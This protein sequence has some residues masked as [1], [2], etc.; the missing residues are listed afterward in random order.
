MKRKASR[1]SIVL[2]VMVAIILSVCA[3]GSFARAAKKASIKQK[4]LTVVVGKTKKI[5]VVHKNKKR[6]YVFSTNRNKIATVSKSG[7]VRGKKA[8]KAVITVKET[9][10]QKKKNKTRVVGKVTVNVKKNTN[11][12]PVQKGTQPPAPSTVP[13]AS[14]EPGGSPASSVPEP[15]TEPSGNKPS[16]YVSETGSDSADG[17]QS[18]PFKTLS[19]AKEAVRNLDK[20][21]GDIVVEIADGFYPVEEPVVFTREDSGTDGCTIT[22]RAAEGAKPVFSGGKKIEAKWQAAEEVDWLED[23]RIAYK[24]P[25]ERSEKLRAIYV[26]GERASMTGRSQKPLRPVG[27]YQVSKGEADWAW[28]PST[29]KIYTGAVFAASFGLPADTRN[30]QN[31]E[32][33]SGSTWAKQVVCA[34]SLSLTPEGDTEVALQM[35][36]G[37][38]AQNLGW[39]TAYSPEKTK[40]NDVANVFEWLENP[41]EF[42]FDQEGKMLYY[43]PRDGEDLSTAEVVVPETDTLLEI[44]GDARKS[45]YVEN[46]TFEGLGFAYTD[47]NLYELEGSHGYASVQGSIVLTKF[48]LVN[49][50]DDIYRSYD[51]PPA[52]IHANTAKNI[53]FLDGEVRHTG[54]LGIHLENDVWDCEV[55]GNYIAKTGGAGIVVGH[56]QHV[57]ENDTEIHQVKVSNAAGPD[58][59]KFQDGTEAVPQNIKITNNYL[60]ENCYF[61]PGN[62]P[63]TSFFTY[64]L[65]VLHNFVYKCSYSGMS[66]GWGWCNFDGENGSDS[67]LPGVPTDTSKNNHVNYNRVEEIC[68]LLQDAGGIYTLGRQGNDDWTEY[69]EMSYNYINAKREPQVANGS[70][71]INGFHPDEGSAYIKFDSNVVTNIIRNV[72]ELND[73]RRKHDM[74]VTNG[75][76][77]TSRSETTA[78][79]CSLEQY[80]NEQY[81]WPL[82]GYETVLYSGLEDAYVHMVGK[83]VI[84][85][86]DYELASHVRLAAGQK[87]PRRGLL[88]KEDEVW[89][90][91]EGTGTFAEG[92]TMTKA[93]G[94]EKSMEIPK[95]PGEYKLYIRYA[96][97]TVSDAS[98]YTLYVGEETDAANV[99]EGQNYNV[100]KL[101]PLKLELKD[102]A[103]QFTLNGKEISNGETISQAGVWT[104]KVKEQGTSKESTLTFSTT[105]T[106]ANLLLEDNVTVAGGQPVSFSNTLSDAGKTIWL[107]PSGLSAFDEN[108][109][110]MSRADGNSSSMKAPVQPGVYI[111]TVVGPNGEIISQSD[112]KVTVN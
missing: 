9:F 32:L 79:N 83:D 65:Q 94:D 35:P 8:G 28:A 26:N 14:G 99:S 100:S 3:P 110:S 106:E 20:K 88:Q 71:M 13:S 41:G 108:D 12:K 2:V 17:S 62:S 44:S 96:D 75:F 80:V 48:A 90:A 78:L 58:K 112:A 85:D 104:L 36:Y 67:Q 84:P 6:K 39:G 56:P 50:H 51:V 19:R 11:T 92:E 10:K 46:V 15:T 27:S 63:V 37:A 59:E 55:T 34:E 24:T 81:I 30:P 5:K 23:G 68:S 66:I 91:E 74:I 69:S 18:Q 109:P 21:N 111:L 1:D 43:I 93:A 16:F 61:F 29:T 31:I 98:T 25:L 38:L 64:N 49:Q 73:W 52:A 22:Y 86:T 40:V 87:L 72:Y 7:V 95:Q 76:S 97:G 33:E 4:K 45:E 77:N 82:K 47:W 89:L 42:Y 107:A 60:Y 103:Y 105:V 102:D 54:Y 70:K 53:R 57:Y 101:R